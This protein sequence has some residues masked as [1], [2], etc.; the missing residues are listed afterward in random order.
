MKLLNLFK[1]SKVAEN[2]D[3]FAEYFLNTSSEEKKK[4]I[5]HAAQR[6]NEDQR[7]LLKSVQHKTS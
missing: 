6:A 5:K 4:V 7:A 2:S 1:T 3:S